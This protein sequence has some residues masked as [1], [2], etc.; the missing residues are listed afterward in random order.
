VSDY[1][2]DDQ[3]QSPVEAKHSSCSLCVQKST[4]I[5][6]ASY[7]MGTGDPFLGIMCGWGMMLTTHPLLVP[8]SRISR[9][10]TSTPPWCLYGDSETALLYFIE[11]RN[12]KLSFIWVMINTGVL[13]IH[14]ASEK[15]IL[16]YSSKLLCISTVPAV[17]LRGR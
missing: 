11:Y 13:N 4:E 14:M 1:K 2:L 17:L 9:S 10:Y 3:F 6:Q 12:R 5:Y 15:H 16:H 7:P 8:R